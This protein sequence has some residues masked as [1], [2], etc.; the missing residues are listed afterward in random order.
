MIKAIMYIM[1]VH[2]SKLLCN[3]QMYIKTYISCKI[4]DCSIMCEEN[5]PTSEKNIAYY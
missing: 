1:G 4:H 2:R 5:L 3:M